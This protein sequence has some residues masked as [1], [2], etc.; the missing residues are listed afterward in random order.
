MRVPGEEQKV[1]LE[2]LV[3]GCL[4]VPK[5]LRPAVSPLRKDILALALVLSQSE[6]DC[7]CDLVTATSSPFLVCVCT[8]LATKGWAHRI[9]C[10]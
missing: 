10:R 9:S 4:M 7:F 3:L 8:Q 6:P 1:V 2:S 5:L